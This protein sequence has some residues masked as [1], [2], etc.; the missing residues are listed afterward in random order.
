MRIVDLLGGLPLALRSA[1]SY[2]YEV[3]ISATQYL[4]LFERRSKEI[5]EK[6]PALTEYKESL[7]TTWDISFQQIMTVNPDAARFLGVCAFLD[8]S[9][10]WYDLFRLGTAEEQ[11]E[12]MKIDQDELYEQWLLD[13]GRDEERFYDVIG[14]LHKYHFIRKLRDAECYSIHPM[15]HKW[16]RIRLQGDEARMNLTYAYS[17]VANA[18]PASEE[19]GSSALQSRLLPHA[20]FC[21]RLR[22]KEVQGVNSIRALWGI[23]WLYRDQ[24]RLLDAKTAALDAL[25]LLRER[26]G[27][28]HPETLKAMNLLG[29][30]YR[31][32]GNLHESSDMLEHGLA[33]CTSVLGPSN[34]NTLRAKNDL[35]MVYEEL[36]MMN[37]AEK[38]YR[39]ALAGE[40]AEFGPGDMSV[41][42]TLGNL[43]NLYSDIGR[44]PE[45]ESCYKRALAG[46]K[47]LVGDDHRSTVFTIDNLGHLY[48]I[49]GRLDEAQPLLKRALQYRIKT[50]RFF[51]PST[52]RSFDHMARLCQEKGDLRTAENMFLQALEGRERVLGKEHPNTRSSVCSYGLL[53]EANG[54]LEDAESSFQR[55][56]DSR[57]D[58]LGEDNFWTEQVRV[59]LNRV[60]HEQGKS[61]IRRPASAQRDL[62]H[63]RSDTWPSDALHRS[64]DPVLVDPAQRE[65]LPSTSNVE[66]SPT[67]QV[68]GRPQTVPSDSIGRGSSTRHVIEPQLDSNESM[69]PP[70][71][72]RSRPSTTPAYVESRS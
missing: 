10:I 54:R 11:M 1:G 8:F 22:Q 3:Q 51:H 28:E 27:P 25:R 43:G 45:A 19:A 31:K 66:V 72:S 36:G 48:T 50:M 65:R 12:K 49:T 55:V 61:I 68:D 57:K 17:L 35:G 41:M 16:A 38:L 62:D 59:M 42:R 40:E 67:A 24:G 46:K 34:E 30:I 4:S 47:A 18:V 9:D 6:A 15:V 5:M 21:A 71:S 7:L 33:G 56:Y 29:I 20:E 64:I 70:T 32:M 13:I 58:D 69:E 52:L 26:L 53:Y 23:A 60:R 63:P 39:E 37:E 14:S 2:M 44:Y